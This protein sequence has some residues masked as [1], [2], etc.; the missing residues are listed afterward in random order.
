MIIA[1]LLHLSVE[2]AAAKRQ[3]SPPK[4]LSWRFGKM[5]NL[6]SGKNDNRKSLVGTAF[7][8]TW[9]MPNHLV[10][11]NILGIVR[12]C[13]LGEMTQ[14]NKTDAP[15]LSI[16][17][18]HRDSDPFSEVWTSSGPVEHKT[19]RNFRFAFDGENLFGCT[20]FGNGATG[21]SLGQLTQKAYTELFGYLN[22]L[23][24]RRFVW[25]EVARSTKHL[26]PPQLSFRP[27]RA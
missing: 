17:A 15:F 19:M 3:A 5:T 10:T 12:F 23:G 21:S 14:S 24:Y 16:E 26:N 8:S 4:K 13:R 6:V 9:P 1:D 22:Q 25:V 11:K 7:Y 20:L 18:V 2:S 27:Q